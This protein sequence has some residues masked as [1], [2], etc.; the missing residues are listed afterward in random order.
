MPYRVKRGRLLFLDDFGREI[1]WIEIPALAI[2]GTADICNSETGVP[3]ISIMREGKRS[4]MVK[5]SLSAERAI[6]EIINREALGE[7]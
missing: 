4:F 7:C 1:G 3:V 2:G 6:L 5:T